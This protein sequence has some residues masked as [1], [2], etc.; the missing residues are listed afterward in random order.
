MCGLL[1]QMSRTKPYTCF[2]LK[3]PMQNT[4]KTLK[5]HLDHT[6]L[7]SLFCLDD[8]LKDIRILSRKGTKYTRFCLPYT[9]KNETQWRC[10][11]EEALNQSILSLQAE[12]VP[13][14]NN[15]PSEMRVT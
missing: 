9:C 15:C 3:Y 12:N 13:I 7:F 2:A 11:L 14:S 5:I 1:F 10:V 4:K 6:R 8:F